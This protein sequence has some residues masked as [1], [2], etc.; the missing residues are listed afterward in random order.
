MAHA[1]LSH[2]RTHNILLMSR[3]L[4]QREGASPLTLILDTLEQPAHPLLREYTRRSQV[5]L[6]PNTVL[7]LTTAA[8][9]EPLNFPVI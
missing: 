4:N 5:R 9:E 7:C 3:L 2:R 1:N 6:S 8:F